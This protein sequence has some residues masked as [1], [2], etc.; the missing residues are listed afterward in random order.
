MQLRLSQPLGSAGCQHR[1]RGP[2]SSR[3]VGGA[4]EGGRH[5][6]SRD[7][8]PEIPDPLES[9]SEGL[10]PS[11]RQDPGREKSGRG[12]VGAHT[13][14]VPQKFPG[15][16]GTPPSVFNSLSS[17]WGAVGGHLRKTPPHGPLS[18]KR[19][20]LVQTSNKHTGD[21]CSFTPALRPLRRAFS[22]TPLSSLL[23][24]F[25]SFFSSISLFLSLFF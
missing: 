14:R 5:K 15:C 17:C 18:Y 20:L 8:G 4:S 23:S 16:K 19:A 25:L 2:G 13:F 1:V 3:A 24:N 21:Y 6:S 22:Y 11:P 10:C 7:T 12:R 9:S